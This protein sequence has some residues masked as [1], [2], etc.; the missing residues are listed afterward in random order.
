MQS[1]I[2]KVYTN[3]LENS[4]IKMYHGEFKCADWAGLEQ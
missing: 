1:E 2:K 4:N 3:L